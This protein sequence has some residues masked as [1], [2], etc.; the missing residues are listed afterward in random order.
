MEHEELGV[1]LVQVVLVAAHL[2]VHV[3]DG[4]SVCVCGYGVG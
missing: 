2:D 1:A 4:V 3:V